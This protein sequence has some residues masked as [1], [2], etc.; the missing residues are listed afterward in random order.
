MM[1]AGMNEIHE[2]CDEDQK[3]TVL[4]VEDNEQALK[5]FSLHLTQAGYRIII[6]RTG[7]EG[8]KRAQECRPVAIILDLIL[9]VM[10]GW[11]VLTRLK[12]SETTHRIPV[13]IVSVLDQP[14]L[15]HR[16]GACDY[17]VKPVDRSELFRAL[18]R[19]KLQS[20]FSGKPPR[21]MIGHNDP[22]ELSLLAKAIFRAGYD[23]I[24]SLSGMESVHL[25][26][27]SSPD[28]IVIDLH[29]SDGDCFE[30]ITALRNH[31]ATRNIPI[32]IL[33]S[34][35]QRPVQKALLQGKIE[36]LVLNGSGKQ[37]ALLA[38]IDDILHEVES[39]SAKGAP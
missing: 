15:G 35:A 37:E 13:V 9:P 24:Q 17:L 12:A 6:A 26:Q 23:V 10:D 18:E 21:I 27:T 19:C 11:E 36:Y 16:L 14:C 7:E 38:A 28:L 33:I 34:K 31:P 22:F 29:L 2:S 4:V 39:I 1:H 5:L 3:N 8:L 25:A 32:R 30:V 20:R